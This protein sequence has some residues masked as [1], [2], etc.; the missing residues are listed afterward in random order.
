[1]KTN[2]KTVEE[3]LAGTPEPARST[4]RSMRE[5]ILSVLP[6]GG[7]EAI[8][9]GMPMFAYKGVLVGIAAYKTH[10]A[11]YAGVIQKFK[12][13]LKGYSTAKGTVRY[14]VDKPLPAPLVR[15]MLKMRIAENEA[16]AA[17]RKKAR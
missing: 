13:D 1:M 5:V 17:K 16:K 10:C 7:S 3:Y 6:P 14:P 15:K 12:K 4:L 11:L 9:Y 8:S 2:I